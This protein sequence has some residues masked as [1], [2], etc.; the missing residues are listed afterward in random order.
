M[1]CLD[2]IGIQR[3]GDSDMGLHEQ[4][5]KLMGCEGR[6]PS[7]GISKAMTNSEH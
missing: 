4:G 6:G 7:H 2:E 5:G 3:F 1:V